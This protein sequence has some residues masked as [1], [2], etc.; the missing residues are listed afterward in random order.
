MATAMEDWHPRD[1]GLALGL[2]TDEVWRIIEK[3]KDIYKQR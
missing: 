1:L 2:N 3:A